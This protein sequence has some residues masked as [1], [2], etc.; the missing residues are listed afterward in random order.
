MSVFIYAINIETT[1]L[2]QVKSL[3]PIVS[4]ERKGI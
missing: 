3:E 4:K 1:T 2:E